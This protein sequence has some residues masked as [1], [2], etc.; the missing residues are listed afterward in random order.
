MKIIYLNAEESSNLLFDNQS[1]I[2]GLVLAHDGKEEFSLKDFEQAF[3]FNIVD[4]SD[5]GYMFFVD[6]EQAEDDYPCTDCDD[7]LLPDDCVCI[8]QD[9]CAKWEKYTNQ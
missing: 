4:I 2:K 7:L 1:E 3:N 9:E 8:N 6:D 5:L